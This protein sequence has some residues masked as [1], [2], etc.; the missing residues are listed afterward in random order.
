GIV[1]VAPL[2]GFAVLAFGPGTA[3]AQSVVTIDVFDFDF[4]NASTR[5]HIDP[6]INVGD[7]VRWQWGEGFHSTTSVQGIAESWNSG[8]QGLS[9]TFD[10]TFTRA[11]TFPYYCSV[12]GVDA[13]GGTT[14]GMA[15]LVTVRPVPEPAA[16][17]LISG[18]ASACFY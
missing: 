10:H 8:V 18:L 5:T 4:G 13:G 6:T 12:H 15:G 14:S 2:V 1:W 9:F 11:G 3:T 7:T 16:I 17:L